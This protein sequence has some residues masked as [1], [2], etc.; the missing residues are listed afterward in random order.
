MTVARLDDAFATARA[1]DRAALVG[2]LPAGFPDAD[3]CVAAFEALAQGGVDVFEIGL[4][5]TD[6]VMDGPVIQA[7]VQRC[8]DAKTGTRDVLSTVERVV[9]ATGVPTVVMT[10]WNPVRRYGA[11]AFARDLA[12][13][14]GSG[15]V[16]PDLLPEEGADWI[17]AATAHDVAPV[18]IAAQTSTAERL[19]VV[20][21]VNRGFVYAASTLGVTGVRGAVS[22]T[23]ELLVD[24]VRASTSLPVA[25]GLGVSDGE[26]AA[27]V[28]A[29]AD[30]VIVGSALV[31]VLLDDEGLSGRERLSR[32]ASD[33]AAGVR[34]R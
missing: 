24:R 28:A 32:L 29:Y 21:E 4:P 2:Y 15:V 1:E 22:T 11:D 13:A 10:Y 6:P 7:A 14:G 20:G 8:L 3:G 9:A 25:V 31:Q 23:A 27:S 17:A 33:L 5:Y 18:F 12:A 34:R 16:T 30:G 26:Q 19:R